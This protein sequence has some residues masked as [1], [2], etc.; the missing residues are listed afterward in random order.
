MWIRDALTAQQKTTTPKQNLVI[1]SIENG[2]QSAIT[3]TNCNSERY[4]KH[5]QLTRVH[6]QDM[7]MESCVAHL[8]A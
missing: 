2:M 7:A 1:K 6:E 3:K 8:V 5:G 4:S